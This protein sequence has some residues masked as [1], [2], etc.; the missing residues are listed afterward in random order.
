MD[1]SCVDIPRLTFLERAFSVVV[2]RLNSTVGAVR[3][4][5]SLRFR[6]T[7]KGRK[8]Q[9]PTQGEQEPLFKKGYM[10]K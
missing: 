10:K 3:N 6:L 8:L 7:Y 5:E 1:R 9:G 4:A 2:C